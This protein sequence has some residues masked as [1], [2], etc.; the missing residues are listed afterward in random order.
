MCPNLGSLNLFIENPVLSGI[1]SNKGKLLKLLGF[2][3][4]LKIRLYECK[5]CQK[6]YKLC[7]K[8]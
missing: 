6:K 1:P 5:N 3:M 7:R 8:I 4:R 2:F